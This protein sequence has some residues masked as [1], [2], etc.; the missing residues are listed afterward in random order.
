MFE[1]NKWLLGLI[2]GTM[3]FS[4]IAILDEVVIK[5]IFAASGALA[6]ALVGSILS[7]GLILSKADAGQ[8]RMGFFA[9]LVVIFLA[10]YMAIINFVTWVLSFPLYV[11]IIIFVVSMSL[12]LLRVYLNRK[13]NQRYEEEYLSNELKDIVDEV[14]KVEEKSK[15]MEYPSPEPKTIFELLNENKDK[16]V[17]YVERIDN[18]SPGLQYVQVNRD[19]L[20]Y[21]V[22]KGYLKYDNAGKFREIYYAKE[23][24]WRMYSLMN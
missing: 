10:I 14:K 22:L 20:H 7:T 3:T 23:K 24:I 5:V 6:Y 12:L 17:I 13:V 9:I 19:A 1:R 21:P 15:K 4:G 11:Y 2:V 16:Q 18:K 8:L